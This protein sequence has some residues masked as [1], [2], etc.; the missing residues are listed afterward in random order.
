MINRIRF[1]FS[2]LAVALVSGLLESAAW[3]EDKTVETLDLIEEWVEDGIY[4]TSAQFESDYANDVPDNLKHR[5][6]YQVFHKVEI[7]WL[8][9]ITIFQQGS[10]DGTIE[11]TMRAGILHFFADPA[12][13]KVR[14]REHNFIIVEDWVDAYKDPEKIASITADDVVF[15]EGCDFYLEVSD[16]RSEIRGPMP[17]G[18]CKLPAEQLG[19]ELTAEDEVVIRPGEFWFLGRYV[20]DEGNVMWGTESDELNKLVLQR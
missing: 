13:G 1:S 4:D 10:A 8:D 20:D 7:D 3:A 5:L 16:D 12:I 11:T 14:Q 6:M 17:E 2:I 15:S 19:I 9:G 18:T